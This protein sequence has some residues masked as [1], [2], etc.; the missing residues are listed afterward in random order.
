MILLN[1]ETEEMCYS[2]QK[3]SD[4]DEEHRPACDIS[5]GTNQTPYLTAR[6]SSGHIKNET[7]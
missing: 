6:L 7:I 2:Y 1:C 4:W 5:L 3:G